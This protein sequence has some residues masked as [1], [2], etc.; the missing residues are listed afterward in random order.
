MQQT[1]FQPSAQEF[2]VRGESEKPSSLMSKL[3]K[4]GS[5]SPLPSQENLLLVHLK[6]SGNPQ[7]NGERVQSVVGELGTVDLVLIDEDKAKRYPVGHIMIQFK[8]TPTDSELKKLAKKYPLQVL[9]RNKYAPE[10]VVFVPQKI[11]PYLPEM[12]DQIQSQ[13]EV[14]AVWP[15]TLSTFQRG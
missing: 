7:E 14:V 5:V 12:L 4:L 8:K 13:E 11:A 3:L 6:E 1:K 10:Q 9:K 15:E 2:V